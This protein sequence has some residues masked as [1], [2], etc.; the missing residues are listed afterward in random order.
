M[1]TVKS[2]ILILT[3]VTNVVLRNTTLILQ[4]NV[5]MAL[6][7]IANITNHLAYV[8]NATKAIESKQA[9]V[10]PAQ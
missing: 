6:F 10:S 4:T 3:H 2:A 7:R 5:K 8:L 1:K 9:C